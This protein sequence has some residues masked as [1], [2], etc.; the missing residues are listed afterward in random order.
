M[1]LRPFSIGLKQLVH[2]EEREGHEDRITLTASKKNFLPSCSS[3]ASWSDSCFWLQLRRAVPFVVKAAFLP[4]LTYAAAA[5]R[6]AEK[7]S[8][9]IHQP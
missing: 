9:T 6:R 3:C 5:S 4:R 2:H 8:E 1:F 7:A